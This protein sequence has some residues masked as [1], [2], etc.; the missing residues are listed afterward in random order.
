MFGL[1]S[2]LS[3]ACFW[4]HPKKDLRKC[5]HILLWCKKMLRP[6]NAIGNI[7][8]KQS[9]PSFGPVVEQRFVK[10]VKKTKAMSMWLENLVVIVIEWYGCSS[11]SG[12]LAF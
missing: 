10:S 1:S 8:V 3:V 6:S 2:Q 4:I 9:C 5:L 11:K 7:K 12:C